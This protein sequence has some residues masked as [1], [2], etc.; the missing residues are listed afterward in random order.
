MNSGISS[1]QGGP[2]LLDIRLSYS[3]NS[4]PLIRLSYAEFGFSYTA[5]EQTLGLSHNDAVK[6]RRELYFVSTKCQKCR[7]QW[8][9]GLRCG[10]A[11]VR[12]LGL[13]VRITPEAWM[14]VFCECCVLSGTGL[15][16]GLITRPEA[17]YQV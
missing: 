8:P 1:V 7:S 6:P 12:S 17:S 5:D 15:C 14:P 3:I 2:R 16:D 9:R 11:A 10:S 13:R 4:H